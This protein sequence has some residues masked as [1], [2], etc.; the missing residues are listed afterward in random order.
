MKNLIFLSVFIILVSSKVHGQNSAVDKITL[1]QK[2]VVD[3]LTA[4]WDDDN[5]PGGAMALILDGQLV[6]Q[7][8]RGYSQIETSEKNAV[9]TMFPL[10]QLSNSFLAYTLLHLETENKLSLE[11]PVSKYVPSLPKWANKVQLKQL[12][13]HSSGVHDFVVLQ[14]IV[15]WK[16]NDIV[17]KESAIR[18]IASQK[19]LSFA[20]GTEFVFSRSNLFLVSEIIERVSELPLS[21]YMEQ[22]IFKP[23]GLGN[24]KVLTTENQR[25]PGLAISY[26][27]D[28]NNGIVPIK[29]RKET[30]AEVNI[31]SSIADMAKWE[32]H[33][34]KPQSEIAKTTVKKF[35]AVV[36][37]KNGAKFS[38]PS[39]DLIYGQ[40]YIHKERGLE[41]AM[42]TGGIDGYAAA[43]FNFP[44]R[45]FTAI[46]LSNNGEPYN[47]YIGMLSAHTFLK[48]LFP[49]PPT[50]DF[51]K[52]KTIKLKPNY[53]KKYV[54]TYW[55]AEGELSRE[56]KIENDTLR[57]V[58]SNGYTSSLIPI[59]KD[60]FQMIVEFDDKIFLTFNDVNGN[61]SMKYAYGEATPF[62]FVKYTQRVYSES[63]L[64]HS[65]SGNYYCEE[66]G[67]GYRLSANNGKLIASNVKADSIV[68][69]SVM[70]G[71]FAGDMWY[72]RSIEFQSADTGE[73]EGFYVRNDAIRNLLFKKIIN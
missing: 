46:T 51:T 16:E 53:H 30:Y 3:S 38:V 59:T 33:L 52:I 47:G 58:R 43:I 69:S 32:L 72:M 6:Y 67:V 73:I 20:P 45:N 23:L 26:R 37:L 61:I 44:I 65:F 11:D 48:G 40:K 21:Q 10:G 31:V 24:T 60:K 68:L 18:L 36:T 19:E 56:I 49:E 55:D 63:Q 71:V 2:N 42:S 29:S 50:I 27:T 5:R 35:N 8:A 41:T 39:G 22:H 57:Y 66:L 25:N 54:G 4:H 17:K 70:D 12:L 9:K 28:E 15:G 62:E 13:Q 14:H 64:Q 34:L 7:N 1:E